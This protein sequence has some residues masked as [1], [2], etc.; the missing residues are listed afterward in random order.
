MI[1]YKNITTIIFDLDGTLRDHYPRYEDEIFKI[2]QKYELED[3]QEILRSGFRWA[4][5][6]WAQSEEL[7]EDRKEYNEFDDLFR[8][9]YIRRFLN[10]FGLKDKHI[11]ACFKD[12]IDKIEDGFQS[13]DLVPDDVL[14]T[15][16]KLREANYQIGLITNRGRP[17]DEYLEEID[18]KSRLDFYYTA[19]EYDSWKPDPEIFMPALDMANAK[20]AEIMYV[21]DNPF[22]DVNGSR[23][24]GFKPILIDRK[25]LFPETD[26]P[27]IKNISEI[28]PILGL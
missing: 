7:L 9:R 20:P 10:V 28:L 25:D 27:I 22:A 3:D 4:H 18:L 8:D 14:P 21:G 1:D 23:N 12:I 5:Y 26:C 24:V 13:K 19:G 17:I 2:A 11:E 6:Y 16:D 15:L